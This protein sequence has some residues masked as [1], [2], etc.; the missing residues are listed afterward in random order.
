MIKRLGDFGLKLKA[1]K[2]KIFHTQ[3]SYLVHVVS[4]LGMSADPEK[5]NALEWL[6]H[7]PK[8]VSELQIFLGFA[9]Y[10]RSFVKGFAQIAKP[11]HQLAAQKSKKKPARKLLFQ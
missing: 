8:N 7:P 9:G 6:Q 1:S 3:L 2:C 10:Y 5:I 4:T 11:L